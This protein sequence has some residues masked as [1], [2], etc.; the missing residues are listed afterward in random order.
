V[1]LV[2]TD[3][4]PVFCLATTVRF[5]YTDNAPILR[6]QLTQTKLRTKERDHCSAENLNWLHTL[7]QCGW[8]STGQNF[9]GKRT[10]ASC[11]AGLC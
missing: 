9:A 4:D 7:V 1:A 3:R 5:T 2:G 8:L 11:P 6:W 10:L